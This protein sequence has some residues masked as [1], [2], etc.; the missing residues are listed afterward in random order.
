MDYFDGVY[1]AIRS[2]GQP[3]VSAEDGLRVITIIEAAFESSKQKK[4][5]QLAPR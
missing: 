4:V 3:P 1:N 5:I 2:N